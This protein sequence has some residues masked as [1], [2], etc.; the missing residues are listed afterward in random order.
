MHF[1]RTKNFLQ[2]KG[3]M[4]NEIDNICEIIERIHRA[5]VKSEEAA[6]AILRILDQM[7]EIE[8]LMEEEI[9]V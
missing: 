1:I 5:C 2:G 9:N 8:Q 4:M 3:G 7:N 6:G